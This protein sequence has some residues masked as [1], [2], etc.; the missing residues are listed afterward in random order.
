ME[1]SVKIA[2]VGGGVAGSSVAI[3]LGSMGLDITL[4]EKKSSLV[5]GPPM[6]HLHAGGN[7]YPDI[8]ME[9]CVKLLKES[10]DLIH[11][12]PQAIDYRPTLIAIPTYDTNKPSDLLKKLS[13]LQNEYAK[14]VQVDERNKV[15]GDPKNYFKSYNKEDLI[16][17]KESN[18]YVEWI[19]PFV[20]EVDL[21]AIKYPIFLVQ[22]YGLNVFRIAAS[23][24]TLLEKYK[25]VS[26][27]LNSEITKIV[28]DNGYKIEYIKDNNRY[29][30]KFDYLINAA[31]FESG[32][33]DDYIEKKRDRFVEFKAAYV[34]K[35][36]ENTHK[37][38]EVIFFGKRGSSRGMRQFTPYSCNYFQIHTMTKDVT[39]FDN[40]LVKSSKTS[41]MPKLNDDFLNKIYYEW[42]WSEVEDR[43]NRSIEYVSNFIK[44][45]KS[46]KV[47]SK[48]L[49]GA[50]QIPGVE[51]SLR[52]AE[53][54]FDGE[55]YARC[56]IVKASSVLSMADDIMLK[57]IEK[58]IVDKGM[59]KHRDYDKYYVEKELI[60]DLSTKIAISRG[61]PK[62]MGLLYSETLYN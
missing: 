44:N 45:F 13:I 59:Y 16:R 7:L 11:L 28:D 55:S 43:T 52:A 36:E 20:K 15:L 21:E 35:W 29:T 51:D 32:K 41:S 10:I 14:L 58:N 34:T 57:L 6:C 49:Y 62:C 54:S 8:S 46:A 9:Q 33:I 2:V 19:T 4:F 60:D 38:A 25:N 42:K 1:D 30:E 50:Q 26:L 56:E 61:Y 24:T 53:V 37:W 27:N 3:Y 17:I 12:Y 23:A 48:P 47:A 39:L 31:G 22:E 40:G 18:E 5:D